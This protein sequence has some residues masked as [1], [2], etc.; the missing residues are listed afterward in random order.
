MA[1]QAVVAPGLVLC[2]ALLFDCDVF[3]AIGMCECVDADSAQ[4]LSHH[5]C[6]RVQMN[7]PIFRFQT[8]IPE[9][10]IGGCVTFLLATSSC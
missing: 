1:L 7:M 5:H 8:L 3:L 4:R 10:S 2:G 6:T 9:F